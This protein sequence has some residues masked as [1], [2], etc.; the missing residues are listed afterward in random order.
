MGKATAFKIGRYIHT[1]HPNKCSIKS[2][3]EKGAWAYPGA[4]QSFKIHLI[5]SGTDKATDFK[6]GSMHKKA[7]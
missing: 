6:F 1:V 2:L 3:G 4:A 7:H 5:I